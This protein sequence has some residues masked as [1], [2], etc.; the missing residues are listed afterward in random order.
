MK[1]HWSLDSLL[2]ENYQRGLMPPKLKLD[3]QN[4]PLNHFS[5]PTAQMNRQK[6]IVSCPKTSHIIIKDR[7]LEMVGVSNKEFMCLN[8]FFL[9]V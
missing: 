5:I 4:L 7:Y 8:A 1:S 3:G 9:S 6:S 2:L